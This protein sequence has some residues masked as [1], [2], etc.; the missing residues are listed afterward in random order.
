M[1]TPLETLYLQDPDPAAYARGYLRRLAALLEALDPAAIARATE[2]IWAAREEGRKIL[3]IGNGGSAATASHFA[4]DIGIGT[5]SAGAPF[6]ALAL[7]DNNAVMTAIAN[8]SGYDQVFVQQLQMHLEPGDL[9]VA[10]SASGNSPNVVKAVEL[11]RERGNTVIGLTGFD[12]GELGRRSHIH[13]HAP[14]EKGEYGPVEDVHMILDHLM[15][16]FL[17]MRARAR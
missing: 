7:T 8:D 2:A 17:A 6:K 5:R 4:N 15:S 1:T 13:V 12:G 9:L 14:T 10:I 16:S 3:F 11:A